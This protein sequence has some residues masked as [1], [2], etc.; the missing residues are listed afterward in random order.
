[1]REVVELSSWKEK[2]ETESTSTGKAVCINCRYDWEAVA[3]AGVEWLECPQCHLMR[4]KFF[5]EHLRTSE[6]HWHCHCGNDLFYMTP[7]GMYCP[8]CGDWQVGL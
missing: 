2:E 1:M 3:P 8:N 6:M 4:G 5:H 7:N